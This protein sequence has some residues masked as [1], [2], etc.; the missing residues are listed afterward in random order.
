M[1]FQKI[2]PPPGNS[3]LVPYFASKILT[4]KAPLPL[5]ISHD[6]PW[7]GY[8]FFLKLY[9]VPYRFSYLDFVVQNEIFLCNIFLVPISSH[10]LGENILLSHAMASKCFRNVMRCRTAHA[11][12]IFAATRLCS[13]IT[14]M[15]ENRKKCH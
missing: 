4:F 10:S 12:P 14:H 15:M 6:L 13:Q 9:N 5:G 2:T 3:H 11:C 1:H 8:G 7:G